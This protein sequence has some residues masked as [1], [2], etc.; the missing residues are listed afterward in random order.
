MEVLYCS[1]QEVG[2]NIFRECYLS[3]Y[4]FHFNTAVVSASAVAPTVNTTPHKETNIE[5]SVI[6]IPFLH[7]R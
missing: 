3:L 2:Y 5:G 1:I 6:N 7:I 4:I